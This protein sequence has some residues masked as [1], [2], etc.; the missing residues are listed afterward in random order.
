MHSHS[1]IEHEEVTGRRLGGMQARAGGRRALRMQYAAAPLEAL[2]GA[3][4]SSSSSRRAHLRLVPSPEP[5]RTPILV[6]VPPLP[7]PLIAEG[8]EI[9][10][11]GTDFVQALAV[12]GFEVLAGLRTVAQLGPLI[13]VGLARELAALRAI[14]NDRRIAYR[15]ER[16]RV[17]RPAGV[18]IARPLPG[19]AEAAVV[20]LVGARAHAVALRL[21]WAHRHWRATALT[22]L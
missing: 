3:P 18:R 11:P 6:P 7:E 12:Q 13:S 19:I 5:E 21:E 14:R 2:K 17:P 8:E 1:D 9:P 22:V 10:E 4:M 15:D 16:R 20:L